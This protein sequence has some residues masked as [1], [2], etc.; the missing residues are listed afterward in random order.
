MTSQLWLLEMAAQVGEAQTVMEIPSIPQ[1]QARFGSR[2]SVPPAWAT[3]LPDCI[4]GCFPLLSEWLLKARPL[5]PYRD[6]VQMDHEIY[7]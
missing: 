6:K 2:I 3:Q 4:P 5:F 1:E 7:I